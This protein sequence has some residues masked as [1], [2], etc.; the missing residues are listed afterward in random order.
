MIIFPRVYNKA[1]CTDFGET[2]LNNILFCY[3]L[4]PWKVQ[5][6]H[7]KYTENK[8][9]AVHYIMYFINNHRYTHIHLVRVTEN[10]C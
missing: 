8:N 10:V 4:V 5:K 7:F 3:N 1:V 2:S 6:V 9:H